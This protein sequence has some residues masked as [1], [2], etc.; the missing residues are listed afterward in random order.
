MDLGSRDLWVEYSKA[1]DRM[2]AETDTPEAPWYTV[3]ADDKRRARLNCIAHI[4]DAIPYKDV[5]PKPMTLPPR[6]KQAKY[7]RR[8]RANTSLCRIVIDLHRRAD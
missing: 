6:K 1:K 8:P 4:L 7:R 5:T 2:F 3:E